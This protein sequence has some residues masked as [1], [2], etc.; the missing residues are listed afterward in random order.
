[1]H[2][3]GADFHKE[4][5][6]GKQHIKSNCS[7]STKLVRSKDVLIQLCNPTAGSRAPRLQCYRARFQGFPGFQDSTVA[8]FQDCKVAGFE[9][10]M[11]PEL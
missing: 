7:K 6:K 10:S 5:D 8:G 2:N 9:S 11:V 1:L 4:I 3:Q